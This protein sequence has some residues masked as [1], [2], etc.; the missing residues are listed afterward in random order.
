MRGDA[1]RLAAMVALALPL[2]ACVADGGSSAKAVTSVPGAPVL[3]PANG[4]RNVNPDTHLVLTFAG[5][6]AIGASGLIRVYDTA[7]NSLVD[8]LDMSVPSSPNPNGRSTATTEAERQAQGQATKM[9]DYQVNT[10]EGVDFH[11]FPIIVRGAT[12]TIYPHNGKLKYGH[13]YAVKMDAGV[14]QAPGGFAGFGEKGWTFTTKLAAPAADAARLTVAADGSGDFNTVQ[15]AL[16]FAPAKPAKRVTVFVQN[17][18]YE[19]LVYLADKSN[20][21]VRGQDRDKVV[22]TYPNNSALNPPRSGPSRRP[23]FSIQN[24]NGVQLQNFTITNSFIGQAEALLVRGKENVIDHMT[25][26][27]SGDALTTY[28]TLYM[29]DS[30]LTGHGDTILGYAS[31]YCLRCELHSIGPF[32]WTRTPQ[33][34]HGNVF[35]DS[36]FV[37]IDEP[38]PWTVSKDN[39]GGQRSK[40][41]FA[42]LPRNGPAGAAN[43]NFPYAEMVLINAKTKGV[44]PEGW[45][46]VE[47]APG[48]DSANVHLWEYNTTDM[49]GRPIDMSQRHPVSK[50]LT[51]PKD[52]ETIA[53]YRKPEFVLGGWKPVIE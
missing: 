43:A 50:Q 22:V 38:L 31:L 12:A 36:T 14:L 10:I 46:P 27:G 6:P 45:G 39:P 29:A 5:A 33:G 28:G 20:I 52:A 40:A 8:T 16:D 23:A 34:S 48:F 13:S 3:F 30:K 44:P 32:T 47:E 42:R 25:L 1:I 49:D 2:A 15:G 19:E 11:F 51:L 37:M 35:V 24:S 26:N 18:T 9:S 53:N 41:V 17:G 21:T 7:D 4:A